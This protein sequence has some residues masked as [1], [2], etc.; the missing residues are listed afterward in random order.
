MSTMYDLAVIVYL[1]IPAALFVALCY[2]FT[3]GFRH[4]G[5]KDI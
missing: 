3:G 5:L 4:W 1:A 2:G